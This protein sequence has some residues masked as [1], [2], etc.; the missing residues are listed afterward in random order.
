LIGAIVLFADA[1][2]AFGRSFS[3]G[4][5]RIFT[6]PAN[7]V[8]SFFN[9]TKLSQQLS[10]LQLENAK[11]QA[12]ISELLERPAEKTIGRY[13][14]LAAKA[15]SEY[16]FND[17]NLVFINVG[18]EQGVSVGM[19]VTV[20]E[21]LLFGK[22]IEVRADKSVVQTVFDPNWKL[23]VRIG[24]SAA[25]GLFIGGSK[26]KISLIEKTKV[27]KEGDVVFSVSSEIPYGLTVARLENI[28]ETA[29]SAYREAAAKLP[30]SISEINQL[31]VILK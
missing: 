27:V 6:L 11:L 2:G 16:P 23:P 29:N 9:Y 4:V 30:Y 14:V 3:L 21:N 5:S 20:A 15:Y 25:A 1:L 13:R 31:F 26:P 28:S 12:E 18:A 8:G 10:A 22:V 17:K 24:D 19:A 7:L